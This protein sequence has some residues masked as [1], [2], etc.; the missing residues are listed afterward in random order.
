MVLRLFITRL[1][2]KPHSFN[3]AGSMFETTVHYFSPN[4]FPSV[5]VLVLPVSMSNNLCPFNSSSFY[6]ALKNESFATME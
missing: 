2:Y 3:A 1:F 6:S 4:T 5:W